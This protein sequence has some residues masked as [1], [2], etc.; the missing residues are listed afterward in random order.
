MNRSLIM[1]LWVKVLDFFMHNFSLCVGC[2]WQFKTVALVAASGQIIDAGSICTNNCYQTERRR[3]AGGRGPGS[4]SDM[5][6]VW[7]VK[8]LAIVPPSLRHTEAG[9]DGSVTILSFYSCLNW[10]CVRKF[11]LKSYMKW[12]LMYGCEG[13]LSPVWSD[14]LPF[15]AGL[16]HHQEARRWPGDQEPHLAPPGSFLL[17]IITSDIPWR[18]NNQPGMSH[19]PRHIC[20]SPHERRVVNI[21]HW[22]EAVNISPFVSLKI[23]DWPR[24]RRTGSN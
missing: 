21:L 19:R 15:L 23:F 2:D 9:H 1:I 4:A 7:H 20:L 8:L 13:M 24:H 22:L 14:L 11:F 18:N 12:C 10:L 17:L 6:Q 3:V 5:W 16:L